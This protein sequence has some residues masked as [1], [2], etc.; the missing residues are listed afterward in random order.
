MTTCKFVPRELCPKKYF[1]KFKLDPRE[2]KRSMAKLLNAAENW[3]HILSN[4]G[5]ADCFVESLHEGIDYRVNISRA[6]FEMLV[7]SNLQEFLQP[8]YSVLKKTGISADKITHVRLYRD[9]T[10]SLFNMELL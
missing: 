7:S 5:S 1:R 10:F 8:I 4:L 9:K 3:K 6:R 2:S